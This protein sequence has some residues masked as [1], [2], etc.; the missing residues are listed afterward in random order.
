MNEVTKNGKSMLVDDKD[1]QKYLDLGWT[2]V[3][4]E[5]E[6]QGEENG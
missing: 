2:V 4:R 5:G 6:T 3:E 1:L